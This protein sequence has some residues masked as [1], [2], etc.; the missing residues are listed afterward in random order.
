[1]R[2]ARSTAR[3]VAARFEVGTRRAALH[4]SS[5]TPVRATTAR[6]RHDCTCLPLRRRY[7]LAAIIFLVAAPAC[8]AVVALVLTWGVV[9]LEG[10]AASRARAEWLD[11][12][13]FWAWLAAWLGWNGCNWGFVRFQLQQSAQ[14]FDLGHMRRRGFERAELTDVDI[15]DV[16]AGVE[17]EAGEDPRSILGVAD[18]KNFKTARADVWEFAAFWRRLAWPGAGY[19]AVPSVL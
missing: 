5:S 11:R 15:A 1:M 9:D 13:L 3:L 4:A 2:A 12:L 18:G 6:S 14:R 8:H 16:R 7:T 10:S 17:S 19:E